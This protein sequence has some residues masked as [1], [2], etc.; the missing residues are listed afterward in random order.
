V[1][2]SLLFDGH[3]CLGGLGYCLFFIFLFF[4]FSFP[5]QALGAGASLPSE[6]A[7]HTRSSIEKVTPALQ[8][9]VGGTSHQPSLRG[10]RTLPAPASAVHS[11]EGGA[12]YDMCFLCSGRRS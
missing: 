2:S 9:T 4:F 7:L 10:V 6:E 12:K 3:F 5:P 11:T 1:W 8:I